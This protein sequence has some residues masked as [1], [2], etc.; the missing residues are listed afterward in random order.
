MTPAKDRKPVPGKSEHQ[1]RARDLA[2]I[3]ATVAACQEATKTWF[4][5]PVKIKIDVDEVLKGF[6]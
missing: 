5:C 4:C 2:I 1:Q 6:T 3:L